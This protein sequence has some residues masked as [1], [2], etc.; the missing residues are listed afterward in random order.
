MLD[1]PLFTHRA[2]LIQ[3]PEQQAFEFA[4]IPAPVRSPEPLPMRCPGRENYL[5]W[6]AELSPP[7]RPGRARRTLPRDR[8]AAPPGRPMTGETRPPSA[9]A[10]GT[11]R[12][13]RIRNYR[14]WA[15]GAFVSNIGTWMQRTAQDWIVLA[16]LTP[17][18]ATAVGIVM[19]LQFGPIALLLPFTGY[20][21]DRF[22]RRKLLVVTQATMGLLALALGLLTVTGLVR[23]WHVYLFALLLGCATAFD[24]PA[25]TRVSRRAARSQVSVTLGLAPRTAKVET[26]PAGVR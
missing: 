6:K 26:P 8:A 12:S 25:R 22:D 10:G 11:F 4:D 20:A 1:T 16:Q 7:G 23:L 3:C 21:A 24:A 14:I 19:S 2:E 18:N 15:V 17:H 5:L 9:P 13:L